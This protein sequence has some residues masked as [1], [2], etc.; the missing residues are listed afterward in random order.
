MSASEEF[1]SQ[2]LKFSGKYVTCLVIMAR[3]DSEVFVENLNLNRFALRASLDQA[4]IEL[5]SLGKNP[6]AISELRLSG[7]WVTL[8][9][10]SKSILQD[11]RNVY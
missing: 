1:E 4:N 3:E 5:G 8:N 10:V 6:S 9:F 2:N 7:V 11:F